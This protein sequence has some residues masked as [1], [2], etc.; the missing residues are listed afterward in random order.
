MPSLDFEVS[1]RYDSSAT[2]IEVP[3]TLSVGKRTLAIGA[4]LDTGAAFCVFERQHAEMLGLDVDSGQLLRF[5]TAA[6]HFAAYGHEIGLKTIGVEVHSMVYFA[7]NPEFK[8]NYL[9]RTGW[10]DRVRLGIV[11]YEQRL[12]LSPYDE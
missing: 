6:G 2:G 10:L 11:D 5:R 12:Y 8:G 3:V 1:H 4:K 9:G 7:E